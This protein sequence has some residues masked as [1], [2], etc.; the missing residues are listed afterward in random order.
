[1]P[2]E[3]KLAF[4]YYLDSYQDLINFTRST[5]Q[6]YAKVS[7]MCIEAHFPYLLKYDQKIYLS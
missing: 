4:C 2:R 3:K 1:M 5:Y 7:R 6:R